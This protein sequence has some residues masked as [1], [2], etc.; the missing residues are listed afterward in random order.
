MEPSDVSAFRIAI[1]TA[2]VLRLLFPE[3]ERWLLPWQA[4][5]WT[6]FRL[7]VSVYCVSVC[8]AVCG[9][10]SLA[11][12]WRSGIDEAAS[13]QLVTTRLYA[14]TRNPTFVGVRLAQLGFF[15][16]GP[17]RSL[18]LSDRRMDR[19]QCAGRIGGSASSA[20]FRRQLRRLS[21]CSGA[22]VSGWQADSL[23]RPAS[24]TGQD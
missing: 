23:K 2:C 13:E 6:G 17:P 11:A 18:C 9:S 7:A 19:C 20:A 8:F 14:F 22:L 4:C 5:K 16:P 3:M 15:L 12:A 21:T 1:W 24:P 10:L